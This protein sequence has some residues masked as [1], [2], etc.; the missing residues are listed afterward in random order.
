LFSQ[1]ASSLC[2]SGKT[3]IFLP[4]LPSGLAPDGKL[5]FHSSRTYRH[6]DQ[7]LESSLRKVLPCGLPVNSLKS[8][9]LI[10]F[11]GTKVQDFTSR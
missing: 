6:P 10:A 7:Q 2:A 8:F 5:G 11:S 3:S 4:G 1:I 9:I